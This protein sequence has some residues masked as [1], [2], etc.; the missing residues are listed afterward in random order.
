M[1]AT[2]PFGKTGQRSSRAVFGAASLG[3]VSQ[4]EADRALE[5]ALSYG[6]NHIDT[7]ASYGESELR[8]KPFLKEH[9]NKVFLA[10]KTGE[11]RY[12]QAKDQ[13]HLSLE[14][15]GVDRVELIQL[16]NLAQPDEW[17]VA[18][19]PGGALEAVI[20]AR[21]AGL[22]KHIGV[23]GHGIGIAA[24]HKKSLER[25]AF[26]SVLLPY[27]YILMQDS[28]YAAD[29]EA[30]MQLCKERGV[31][32]QTIKS[33][34]RRP[35]QSPQTRATWYEPLEDQSSINAMVHW[36]LGRPEVFL[37]T[38]GDVNVLPRVLAA[39]ESF[40]SRPSDIKM[41]GILK[42]REMAPLFT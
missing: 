6:V 26:D 25:F 31:A 30:L 7:A 1:I 8:L 39:A 18:L 10:T 13:F 19:G 34:T 15:L 40:V 41:D 20:E 9:R 3:S 38:V 11:R 22:V 29:F 23:T 28:R 16:H 14:R 21:E 37:C 2:A 33:I 32:V 42:E 5:L 12:Q 17:E 4:A 36:V 35:W 24:L 27:S